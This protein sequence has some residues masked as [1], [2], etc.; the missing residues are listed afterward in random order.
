MNELIENRDRLFKT[1]EVSVLTDSDSL[2][3]DECDSKVVVDDGE[4][5]C[6]SCGLVAENIY[7]TNAT[8]EIEIPLPTNNWWDQKLIETRKI[9][10]RTGLG[11][12][13]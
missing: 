8:V 10:H 9:D 12:I 2:L 4:L 6:D 5:V 3:C 11:S 7:E 13:F 1:R